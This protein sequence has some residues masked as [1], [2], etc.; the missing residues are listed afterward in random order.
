MKL[1]FLEM[2]FSQMIIYSFSPGRSTLITQVDSLV[3][4]KWD[5]DR[6]YALITSTYLTQLALH[7]CF[8][9][10]LCHN[11]NQAFHKHEPPPTE[12]PGLDV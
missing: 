3:K 11:Q 10:H 5:M 9:S 1:L 2:T 12:R 4:E 6:T 7:P 8:G